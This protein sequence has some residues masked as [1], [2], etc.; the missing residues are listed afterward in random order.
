MKNAQLI[1]S[2]ILFIFI[3][4]SLQAQMHDPGFEKVNRKDPNPF[5][6]FYFGYNLVN[7]GISMGPE[8]DFIWSKRQKVQC[9]TGVRY[10]DKHLL[11]VPQFGFFTEPSS[12]FDAFVNIEIDFQTIYD[13]GWIFDLFTSIGYARIFGD[14]ITPLSEMQFEDVITT[15]RGSIMPEFGIGTG[16]SFEKMQKAPI[17]VIFRILSSA[18]NLQNQFFKPAVQAGITYNL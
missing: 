2:L 4:S 11:F 15:S 14:G 18:V 7:P 10:I 13:R 3:F 12:S 8:Y 1:L 9:T 17:T 16:Y 6:I 5:R